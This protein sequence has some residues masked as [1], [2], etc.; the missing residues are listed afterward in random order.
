MGGPSRRIE[1]HYPTMALEDI[2]ALPI[3]DIAYED[4]VLF[5]WATA[6]KLAE[7]IQ[8]V[9]AWGFSYRTCMVWAKD[10]IGLGPQSARAASDLQA[11]KT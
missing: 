2:C 5:L 3:A 11:R 6:P 9:E 8:V 7:S 1:N 10:K 4:S